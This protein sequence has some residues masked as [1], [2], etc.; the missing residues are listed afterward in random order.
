MPTKCPR[1][2]VVASLVSIDLDTA[3]M[4]E[5]EEADYLGGLWGVAVCGSCGSKIDWGF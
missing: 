2:G 5:G 1:C 3:D 4:S